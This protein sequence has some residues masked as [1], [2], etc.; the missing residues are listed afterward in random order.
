MLEHTGTHMDTVESFGTL[1]HTA[2]TLRGK[3]KVLNSDNL[4]SYKYYDVIGHIQS[5]FYI[6]NYWSGA[7][8]CNPPHA[9]V[10]N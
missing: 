8:A 4:R 5:I 7:P 9:S 2:R 6:N 1:K 3:T 10:H